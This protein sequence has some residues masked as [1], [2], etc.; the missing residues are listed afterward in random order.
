[1]DTMKPWDNVPGLNA[2]PFTI[3]YYA[4]RWGVMMIPQ[5]SL[6]RDDDIP[7]DPDRAWFFGD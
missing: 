3:A 2:N 4:S 1:M 6:F 7:I 5:H